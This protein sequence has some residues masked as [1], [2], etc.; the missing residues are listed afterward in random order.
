MSSQSTRRH[1]EGVDASHV[2]AESQRVPGGVQVPTRS[3]GQ[4]GWPV[5]YPQ[6]VDAEGDWTSSALDSLAVEKC[7]G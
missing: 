7:R 1:T 3:Q 6:G 4:A 5:F 2:H